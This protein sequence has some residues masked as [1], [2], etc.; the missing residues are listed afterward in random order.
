M[1]LQEFVTQSR[2]FRWGGEKP[3][4]DDC[5]TFLAR[6]IW[7][8]I[9]I[10]PAEQLRGTY[11]TAEQAHEI[12]DE[13]GGMVAFVARMIEPEIAFRVDD[14]QDG[15]IAIIRAPAGLDG[16]A[17]EIGAIRYG[18][19]WAAMGPGGVIA[20]DA[21]SIECIAAWRIRI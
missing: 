19:L 15:D 12:V 6:F 17:K 10:D 5:L 9:D 3:D 14:V 21:R 11:R 4:D 2:R 18:P 1:T 20:R 8:L 13:H 7:A 16:M